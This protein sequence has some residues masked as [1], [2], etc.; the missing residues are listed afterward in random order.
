MSN[1]RWMN[2]DNVL[3]S[4]ILVLRLTSRGVLR[5]TLLTWSNWWSVNFYCFAECRDHSFGGLEFTGSFDIKIGFYGVFRIYNP[6]KADKCSH[7]HWSRAARRLRGT[8][9][10]AGKLAIGSGFRFTSHRPR[11]LTCE[12]PRSRQPECMI[13]IWSPFCNCFT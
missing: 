5:K 1:C 12:A 8:H 3:P 2:S 13:G 7:P 10:W 11:C 4:Q 6:P 9:R